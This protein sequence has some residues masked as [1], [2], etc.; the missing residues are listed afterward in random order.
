MVKPKKR[1]SGEVG[2]DRRDLPRELYVEGG[3]DRH[4]TLA[5]EC[6][7]AFSKLFEAAGIEQKPRVIACGGRKSAYD[8]FCLALSEARAEVWLLVDAEDLPRPP[9]PSDPW[10]HVASRPGDRWAKPSSA[11][12]DQLHLM[13]VCTE[14]WLLSDRD[15]LTAVFGPKLDVNKLPAEGASLEKKSK[16]F[17][18]DALAAAT[19]GTPSGEYGKGSHSFKVLAKV[20]PTKLRALPW[21]ARFLDEMGHSTSDHIDPE[22]GR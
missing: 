16:A 9:S 18:Y 20:R 8:A 15:A 13:T 6:R 2:P 11:T 5:S 3:G 22:A 14:T 21:A 4:P 10:T 19:K 7:K 17:V 1:A 12:D